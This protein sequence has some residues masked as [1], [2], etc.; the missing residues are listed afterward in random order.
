MKSTATTV[1]DY[2]SE[3][4]EDRKAA[5]TKLRA[6]LKKNMPKGFQ[7]KMYYGMPGYVVPHSLYPP[8]YHCDPKLPLG[9]INFASQKNGLV[10]HH[11]GLYAD[12]KLTEW[13]AAEYVKL[14]IGKLDMGKGCV[15]FKKPENIPFALIGELAK[16]LTVDGWIRS[17]ESAFSRGK[18]KGQENKE[19]R[20]TRTG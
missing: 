6:T 18:E 3:L 8:G 5:I 10:L 17:Y 15:R 20:R 13:F 12:P 16:K 2:I 11:L 14:D 1:D 19:K 4:P 9:L 7:E